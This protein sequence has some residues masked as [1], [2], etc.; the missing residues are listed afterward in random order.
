MVQTVNIVVFKIISL[1]TKFIHGM[2]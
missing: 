1:G 2:S